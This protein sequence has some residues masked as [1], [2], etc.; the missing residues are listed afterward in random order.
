[1]LS[2]STMDGTRG[3]W[4]VE[5]A[6]PPDQFVLG[7]QL[8]RSDVG[9]KRYQPLISIKLNCSKVNFFNQDPAA[10]MPDNDIVPRKEDIRSTKICELADHPMRGVTHRRQRD[11][12][13]YLSRRL[14]RFH[15]ADF[16]LTCDGESNIGVDSKSME[17]FSCPYWQAVT[18][19][20]VRVNDPYRRSGSSPI[21]GIKVLCNNFLW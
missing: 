11:N 7:Y 19:I 21:Y 8:I 12:P 16:E 20:V 5:D 3:Y 1:M 15:G 17:S 6:C 9:G 10:T 14:N 13:V 4:G 2:S 18:G